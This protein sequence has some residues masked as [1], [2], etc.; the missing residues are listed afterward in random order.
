MPKHH[1]WSSYQWA[2]AK[3]CG[4][5]CWKTWRGELLTA[6]L[7]S[8]FIYL[9]NRNSIDFG[10]ALHA[11]AY[12][13]GAFVFWH[14][15]RTPWIL[16]QKLSEADDLKPIWGFCGL[17]F[18]G[19]TFALFIYTAAWLYTMQAPVKLALSPDG[20][21]A[22]IL[23]LEMQLKAGVFEE[24]SDS[25]RRRTTKLADQL[26]RFWIERPTPP[27]PVNPPLTEEERHRNEAFAKYWRETDSSYS[28][29][30][31]N[32]VLGIVRE[33]KNKGVP[34]GFLEAAAENHL[35][36]GSAFSSTGSQPPA[37]FQDELCQLRELAF[38]VDARDQLVSPPF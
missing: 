11:T 3:Q 16:H 7:T 38:Y 1:H 4:K 10:T 24:K 2:F 36:G 20:K 18:I 19:G 13:I 34:T 37:C 29:L 27:Q 5:E 28:K 17:I 9:I 6:A 12:V 25:L 26:S 21:D 8:L 33:Y 35:L 15:A 30:Y 22:R 23:Q 32:R 31:K 14:M